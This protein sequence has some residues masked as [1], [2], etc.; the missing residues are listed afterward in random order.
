MIIIR[1]LQER[2]GLAPLNP[3]QGVEVCPSQPGPAR[4]WGVV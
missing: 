2:D 4:M 3:E 1:I